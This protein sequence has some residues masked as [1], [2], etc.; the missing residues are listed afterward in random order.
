MN[1]FTR[2]NDI[3][4]VPNAL[5]YNNNFEFVGVNQYISN[6]DTTSFELNYQNTPIFTKSFNPSDSSQVNLSTGKFSIPNHF[7]QTDEELI[8]RPKSTFVGIG[9]TAMQYKSSTGIGSLPSTIFA[10]K[11]TNDTFF[12]STERAGTAV[13]FVSVGEGNAH[14]F[15][16]VKKNEKTIIFS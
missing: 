7:F 3:V 6:P 2:K 4:N 10:I 5:Q 15:E 8:Y 14:E 13:T 11:D 16:M 1:F 12:I 9:S